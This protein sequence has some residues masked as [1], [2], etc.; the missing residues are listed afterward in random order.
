MN[1]R[2]YRFDYDSVLFAIDRDCDSYWSNP[3]RNSTFRRAWNSAKAFKT[4]IRMVRRIAFCCVFGRFLFIILVSEM[5]SVYDLPKAEQGSC[6]KRE[7]PPRRLDVTDYQTDVGAEDEVHQH[8]PRAFE[9]SSQRVRLSGL[10]RLGCESSA[11]CTW[12]YG[13]G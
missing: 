13:D 12:S 4:R 6:W 10:H 8:A 7:I 5:P 9:G 3:Q 2:D 1:G 11:L